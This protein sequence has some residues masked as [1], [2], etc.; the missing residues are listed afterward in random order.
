MALELDKFSP[1]GGFPGAPE[2]A[3]SVYSLATNDTLAVVK[4][5]GYFNELRDTL[6]EGDVIIVSANLEH[7]L[8]TVREFAL[9]SVL[10]SP[11]TPSVDNVTIKTKDILDS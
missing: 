5:A 8:P 4:A 9:I 10:A 3:T 6:Y 2:S 11:K 1:V 7:H